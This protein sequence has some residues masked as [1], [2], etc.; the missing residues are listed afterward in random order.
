MSQDRI[1]VND[2]IDPRLVRSFI[3]HALAHD[4]VSD[5]STNC[6]TSTSPTAATTRP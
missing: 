5:G 6:S 3:H 1:T 4:T 2:P